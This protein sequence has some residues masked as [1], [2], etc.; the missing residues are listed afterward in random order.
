MV[1][2]RCHMFYDQRV[3]D[4]K[5]GTPKWTGLDDKSELIED[6][7]K[8]AIEK[9]EKRKKEEAEKKEK[10]KEGEGKK[11]EKDKDGDEEMKQG[12]NKST[13]SDDDSAA[14]QGNEKRGEKRKASS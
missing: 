4:V 8:E 10:E 7:P 5:D 11:N 14:Q 12:G 1:G 3:V 2:I 6:S 9:N 13:G